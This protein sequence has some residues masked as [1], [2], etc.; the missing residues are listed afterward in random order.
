[1]AKK[2]K[3]TEN[4]KL[5]PGIAPTAM[6]MRILEF[7]SRGKLCP[8]RELIKTAEQI[9]GIRRAGALNT[10]VLDEVANSI[11]EGMSTEDINRIVHDFTVKHGG[12]PAPLNYEGFPKSCCTSVNEVVCHGIPSENVILEEANFPALE[13]T[14]CYF[15]T[16]NEKIKNLSL[17]NLEKAGEFF[18]VANSVLE[19]IYLPNLVRA[20]DSFLML[21]KSLR[22]ISLPKLRFLGCEFLCANEDFTL[23]APSLNI[24]GCA[25]ERVR[26]LLFKR[27]NK[28]KQAILPL[29]LIIQNQKD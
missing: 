22:H 12:I 10:A 21:N 11:R 9:K 6:D 18:M 24:S 28:K 29:P 1:V 3:I 7:Q 25:D 13:T 14:L 5:I 2:N 15:L 27:V 19:Q 23:D 20:Y 16:G 26:S 17:P 8:T 4:W